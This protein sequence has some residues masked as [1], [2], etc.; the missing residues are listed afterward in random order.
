M[1]TA[2]ACFGS[3][4]AG[5]PVSIAATLPS[6]YRELLAS[7]YAS[8]D[9]RKATS[10]DRAASAVLQ[11]PCRVGR[12]SGL[13]APKRP[14][15]DRFFAET[16]G[17]GLAGFSRRPAPEENGHLREERACTRRQESALGREDFEQRPTFL[18]CDRSIG[19]TSA[20]AFYATASM[21]RPKSCRVG[22]HVD[23]VTTGAAR[24][25][26]S[27]MR[28]LLAPTPAGRLRLRTR[29]AQKAV[30]SSG[31]RAVCGGRARVPIRRR[32]L[33]ARDRVEKGEGKHCDQ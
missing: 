33:P 23:R 29:P 28:R 13:A 2:F 22:R 6:L 12:A 5:A 18:R 31:P 25:V 32:G 3:S 30:T 1:A 15:A 9:P 17:V 24:T 8:L 27:A 19:R 10:C 14:S 26:R 20:V 11:A 21:G 4:T 16:A 7:L